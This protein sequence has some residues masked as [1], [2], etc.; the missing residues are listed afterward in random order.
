MR[1]LDLLTRT[2]KSRTPPSPHPPPKASLPPISAESEANSPRNFP[3]PY[4]QLPPSSPHLRSQTA[5]IMTREEVEVRALGVSA[6]PGSREL[7]FQPGARS[8]LSIDTAG[9]DHSGVMVH[10]PKDCSSTDELQQRRKSLA[11]LAPELVAPPPPPTVPVVSAED[12][13]ALDIAAVLADC[14]SPDTAR[15]LHGA[16]TLRALSKE[17]DAHRTVLVAA[18]GVVDTL[19][20]LLSEPSGGVSE[21]AITALLNI[22]TSD[23]NRRLLPSMGVL[24]PIVRAL[25]SAA[26]P[27]VVRETAAAAIFSLSVEDDV[28]VAAGDAGAVAHLVEILRFGSQQGKRDACKALFNLS[29]AGCNKARVLEANG[30]PALVEQLTDGSSGIAEKSAAVLANVVTVEAG[31]DA[32]ME[33]EDAVPHLVEVL[34]TGTPRGKEHATVV[35]FQLAYHSE[36]HRAAILMEVVIPPLVRITK[37]GTARARDKATQ[38]LSILRKTT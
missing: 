26:Q 34:E 19:V 11:Q 32:V 4:P 38:L 16:R 31:R 5:G 7:P 36:V 10:V 23:S 29:M 17:S 25:A 9:T 3:P 13:S 20:D 21:E 14:R 6:Y 2:K 24:L 18:D 27:M 37:M 28:K 30:V 1:A 33:E 15:R 22:S 35:L 12:L 8:G